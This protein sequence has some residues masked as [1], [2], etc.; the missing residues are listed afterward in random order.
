MRKE[1][2]IG[3]FGLLALFALY[4]GVSF[5]KGRDLFKQNN[6]FYA[7]YDNVSGI[8]MTTPVMIRGINIGAVTRITFRPDLDNMIQVQMSV[9][10]NYNIPDNSVAR[11]VSTGII[12]GKAIELELG[13]STTYLE[14]GATITAQVEASILDVVGSEF[15]Y[16]KL[17]VS[18]LL[19]GLNNALEGLNAIIGHDGGSIKRLL[20]NV[21]SISATLDTTISSKA[22]SLAL[23][24]DNLT[25]FSNMLAANSSRLDNTLT[26]VERASGSLAEADIA[27]LAG[28]LS[29]TVESINGTLNSTDGTLGLLLNDRGLYDSLVSA[30]SNLTSLLADLEKN[31]KRYV[32][33]SLFGGGKKDK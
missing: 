12:G 7:Y 30:S 15:D 29:A 9:K 4:W 6:T 32:H 19:S 31:P 18:D 1:I 8:Q 13:N 14:D 5:L 33:F 20:V 24:I 2:K 17:K 23:I 10:S 22:D 16:F 27:G 28:R 11:I 25:E 26:N 3:I 21:E